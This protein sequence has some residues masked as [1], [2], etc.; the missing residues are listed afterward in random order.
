M[1]KTQANFPG[2][3]DTLI[4]ERKAPNPVA[5]DDVDIIETAITEIE[6][7]IPRKIKTDATAAPAVT[8]DTTE[9][10]AV[11]SLW[12]DVTNDK[13]YICVDATDG[14][15]VWIEITSQGVGDALTTDPLSQFAAT[16]SAQLAGVI[17]DEIGAGKARFDT[18]VTAKTTTATLTEAEAGTILVSAASAYTITLP[19][20][21]DNVG[22][23]YKVKKTDFNYNLITMATT[24]GQFNYE[25]ADSALKDTYPRLNTGGAEATFISD[26]A[27][28]QVIDEAM[29][30]VPA[31]SLYRTSPDQKNLTSGEYSYV[32]L[33][34]VDYDIG[35][36]SVLTTW[37]SGNCTSTSANHVVD[38][39]GAFTAAMVGKY[40]KNTTD[41]T[42]TYVTAYTSA[43]DITVR[44]DIFVD[45]EG[46]EIKN[47]KIVIPVSGHYEIDMAVLWRG[48]T[49]VAD[50]SYA[51][52]FKKNNDG[53]YET[54]FHSSYV[55]NIAPY[56]RIGLDFD[57][58]DEV[59]LRTYNDSGVDTCDIQGV[60]SV[61]Y[62]YLKVRLISKD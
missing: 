55:G 3:L 41:T 50:K 8:N 7:V 20:P 2:S 48:E 58:D 16:T 37:V 57:K 43:T 46:Y 1:A 22:L 24:A 5:G 32:D 30:Q 56:K 44:D 11:N 31:C 52:G 12:I 6:K 17:S 33:N 61:N 60:S 14:A 26:G 42:Y 25:N 23:T 15:A 40:I 36:N 53:Y 39:G 62:T 9:G 21:V 13:A 27:N 4:V 45:T 47:A 18:S 35:S 51:V 29:G 59:T 49:V 34:M 19:T 38:T 54:F 28:W 10:Y